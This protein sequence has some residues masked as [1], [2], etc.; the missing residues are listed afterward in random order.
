M[1]RLR[2]A[3][4]GER[5]RY[6]G[7]G[8]RGRREDALGG[9]R[10]VLRLPGEER[11]V[12]DFD[13][14]ATL[15]SPSPR[16][17]THRLSPVPTPHGQLHITCTF[18]SHPLFALANK[19]SLLS[20]TFI[21]QDRRAASRSHRRPTPQTLPQ[22]GAHS[23]EELDV[24]ESAVY[25]TVGG[26]DG[27]GLADPLPPS[28]ARFSS[29][30]DTAA[31]L[32][33]Q[34]H[35]GSLGSSPGSG[36]L[37]LRAQAALHASQS[38]SQAQPQPQPQPQAQSQSQQAQQFIQP[39]SSSLYASQLRRPD[40]PTS[41]T[42][43][44]PA[45]GSP[46]GGYFSAFSALPSGRDLPFAVPS[47]SS[48]SP[49]PSL[50][51]REKE[52]E[53][54]RKTSLLSTASGS[55]SVDLPLPPAGQPRRP[56]L[57]APHPFK[58]SDPPSSA[59]TG[60]GG[61]G[62]T[63]ASLAS[64]HPSHPPSP[65]AAYAPRQL[66][67]PT[68]SGGTTSFP[69]AGPSP[70]A[71]DPASSASASASGSGDRPP[72][73]GTRYSSSFTHR[74]SSGSGSAPGTSPLPVPGVR[75][76]G[77][78]AGGSPSLSTSLTGAGSVG[79]RTS[80]GGREGLAG[81]AGAERERQGRVESVPEGEVA[82]GLMGES[83]SLGGS[84]SPSGGSASGSGEAARGGR[85]YSSSFGQRRP[86]LTGS[87]ATS[88]SASGSSGAPARGGSVGSA[89]E[90]T[91]ARAS[92]NL[93]GP[94]VPSGSL[95]QRIP[96]M[97]TPQV[98]DPDLATFLQMLDSG[99]RLSGS[100]GGSG[101]LPSHTQH[102]LAGSSPR[103]SALG[104]QPSDRDR[105]RSGTVRPALPQPRGTLDAQLRAM[106]ARFES[107]LGELGSSPAAAAAGP[108]G[109]SRLR[110]ADVGSPDPF[111][112]DDED[113]DDNGFDARE[114]P[115]VGR[116]GSDELVVGRLEQEPEEGVPIRASGRAGYARSGSRGTER[117]ES[118]DAGERGERTEGRGWR[119]VPTE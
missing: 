70:S 7:S 101:F 67:F 117:A 52:R 100:P 26:D 30:P 43:A 109:I 79:S 95:P 106:E 61:S 25:S 15:V 116:T 23:Y 57:N 104:R 73:R 58:P 71:L 11:G 99:P 5:E 17:H 82:A 34:A 16:T 86:A 38:R 18:L 89:S 36:S 12:L 53:R 45:Q 10:L 33:A 107:S 3:G 80:F 74:Y 63:A 44:T 102:T 37:S 21:T 81:P 62:S 85:R 118:R 88:A 40:S 31:R 20:A 55:S 59:R 78:G 94:S 27:L 4:V 56:S 90:L 28:L 93:S 46:R 42:R 105:Q 9:L 111:A 72:L 50:S 66:P 1:R 75:P 115:R 14:L 83:L 19:E 35:G 8:G 114:R 69:E 47:S 39:P 24:E 68:S 77:A 119:R 60:M 22:Q 41:P 29:S 32:V 108:S 92:P 112:Q 113:D 91:G 65:L 110:Q 97:P 76:S 84:A 64:S 49:S 6:P 96:S 87:G 51:L 103:P 98:D 54:E 48:S 13:A 2:A